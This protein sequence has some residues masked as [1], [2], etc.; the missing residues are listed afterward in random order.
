MKNGASAEIALVGNDGLIGIAL[1]M[2]GETTP[3]RVVVQNAGQALRLDA[4][5][6]QEQF[7]RAGALQRLLLRCFNRSTRSHHAPVPT[8]F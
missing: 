4:R 6:L 2:G 8:V 5:L 1:F 7:R 3:S